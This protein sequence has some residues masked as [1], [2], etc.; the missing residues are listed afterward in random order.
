MIQDAVIVGWSE[1]TFTL[2]AEPRPP[3]LHSDPH[4]IS[5]AINQLSQLL[6]GSVDRYIDQVSYQLINISLCEPP[7]FS[8]SHVYSE[9]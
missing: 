9:G 1:R 8:W 4:G 2:S 3:S 7:T 5:F 6:N